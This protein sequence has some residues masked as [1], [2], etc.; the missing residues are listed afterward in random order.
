MSPMCILWCAS[1]VACLT[2]SRCGRQLNAADLDAKSPIAK[3]PWETMDQTA[4]KVTYLAFLMVLLV[5]LP[6]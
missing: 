3:I 5:G 6:S 1:T 4:N 2:K